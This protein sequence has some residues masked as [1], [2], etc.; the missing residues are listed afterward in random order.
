MPRG[1][2]RVLADDENP[3]V[4]KRLGECPQHLVAHRKVLPTGRDLG[5]EELAHRGDAA[6]HGFK[7]RRPAGIHEFTQRT[8]R[9][10]PS[11]YNRGGCD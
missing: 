1:R 11:P 8:R 2:I 5:P 6:R 3:D 10:G 4:V 7:C 9:H